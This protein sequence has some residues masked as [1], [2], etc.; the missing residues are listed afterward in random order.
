MTIY[1]E[2]AVNVP[3]AVGVFHY[4]LPPELEEQVEVGHLVIVPF[5]KQ[6]VQGVVLSFVDQPSVLETRPVLELVDPAITITRQQIQLA[7][8]IARDCLAPLAS[9]VGLMLPPGLEKQADFLYKPKVRAFMA[10]YPY[11]NGKELNSTQTRLLKL[12]DKRG[13]LRG[14]QIERS[15]SHMDWRAAA[16]TLVRRGL[17]TTQPV[18]PTPT[19]RPKHVRTA[20]LANAPEIASEAIP[21]IGQKDSKAFKRRK[22]ILDFLMRESEPIQVSWIYAETGGNSSDL[23]LLNDL[24]LIEFGESETQRDPLAQYDFQ[25]SSPFTLTSEQKSVWEEVKK[26][27]HQESPPGSNH[28]NT[29]DSEFT[30]MAGNIPGVSQAR[31][32]CDRQSSFGQTFLLHGVTG[33]GKT[34]IYMYAVQEIISL[35][36]QAIIMVPEIALTPQTIRRFAGRFAGQVGLVHSGLSSGERYDTWRRARTGEISLVVG[37]RSAL[38]TPFPNIGLIVVDEC[39]DDSYYQSEAQPYFHARDIAITYSQLTGAICLLGSATPDLSSMYRSKRGEIEYLQLPSRILAHKESVQLQMARICKE[40]SKV[41]PTTKYRTLEAQVEAIDLP[42]VSIVDMRQELKEGNRS[43][44]SQSLQAE[45]VG[46]LKRNLQAILFLN[47]RGTATYVFCR[48]CGYTLKCPRCEVPLTYHQIQGD[49]SLSYSLICHYCNYHRKVPEICPECQ[50][51]RIRHFG[52]GTQRVETEI[53]TMFPEARTLRWDYETTRTKGA[54]DL[55]LNQFVAHRA[56]I[57]IGTQMLAKGLDLPFVTLVGVILADVGLNLPD[58]RA[59]ERVFQVLTQ[60]AGRAGRSPLGG[61]VILQTFQPEHPVIRA[62]AKHDYQTF[63]EV[64]MD[65]RNK[66]GYPPYSNLVRL[67]VSHSN[68]EKVELL[69]SKMASQI[70]EWLEEESRQ[71]TRVIGPVPCFFSKQSGKY[72]WQ[73]ALVGPDPVSLLRGRRLDE[74]RVE[75]NPPSLL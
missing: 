75:V 74:W 65:F 72:R 31:L 71:L 25:P 4:H 19:V 73:I 55:I 38:F 27:I 58:Y 57:L 18:L 66:S 54:H 61:K 56:D 12:L 1:L 21:S 22:A 49:N 14:Q 26:R 45:I 7:Q 68:P 9:C 37:P 64:E 24:G 60:V 46:V 40:V 52:T 70:H 39:H 28:R 8:R 51:P 29:P 15:M 23:R 47:R 11:S 41:S 20:R 32:D 67:E 3:Q 34:E 10:D 69:A 43:I 50:S 42:P 62:A 30:K 6:T 2:V 5:G 33:S 16:R 48:D 63:Y 17:L 44:F 59:N 35:G 53:K 13:P 36:K